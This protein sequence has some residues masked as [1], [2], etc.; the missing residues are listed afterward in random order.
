MTAIRRR[1]FEAAC[2]LV[3]AATMCSAALVAQSGWIKAGGSPGDYDM[4]NDPGTAFTGS[5]SGFIKSNKPNPQTFGTYMQTVDASEYHGKRLQLTAY[6]KS[7][8]VQNWAGLWMRV[9][10]K[11]C[12]PTAFDNM[13]N[14]PIK[15]TSEWTPYRIVL[16]VDPQAVAVAF[17][18]LLAGPGSVW[19]DDVVFDVVGK[20][21]PVT[22]IISQA[23]TAQPRNLDFENGPNKR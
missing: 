18:V 7:D 20:D 6:I 23:S 9:D 1:S 14:R 5:S 11:I 22:D 10:S 2:G 4:G 15:G 16:D 12:N 13:Q 3:L 8:K 17:G 19:I 21:V